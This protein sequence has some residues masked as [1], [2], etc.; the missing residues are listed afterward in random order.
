M[1][2]E[3]AHIS[4][5]DDTLI[6]QWQ[7]GDSAALERL[8]IKYKDRIYNAILRICNNRDTAAELCQ[9]V[10]IK[11]IENVDRFQGKSSFYT[12]AFR[13]AVNVAL[14]YCRRQNVRRAVSLD[15][16]TGG[17]YEQAKA[18]LRNYLADD[19]A[20]DPAVVAQSKEQVELLI[21]AI[22]E[23]DDDQRAVLVLRDIEGMN[24]MQ[25]AAV[26]EIE[27]GTVKSRLSRARANLR[28]KLEVIL[29]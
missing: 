29:Q 12:W 19:V 17:D 4:I 1:Q 11:V 10:F 25:I 3:T 8:I 14:N 27:L 26:I 22:N 24:Y 20:A 16:E 13:I 28:Q 7:R 6:E 2:P 21:A 18:A 9:D 23:L 5:N 15:A